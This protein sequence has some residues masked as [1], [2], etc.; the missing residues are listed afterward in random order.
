SNRG[1]HIDL[2]APGTGILSTVPRYPARRA[3]HTLY[4]AEG[5]DGTSMAAALVTG[6]VALCLARQPTATVRDIRQALHAGADP[7]DGQT[8]FTHR[9]GHGRLN[10]DQTLAAL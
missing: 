2:V 3:H 9:L 5:W 4:D 7:I 10:V 1:A 8:G 6:C